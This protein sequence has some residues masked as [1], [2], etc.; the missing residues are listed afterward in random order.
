MVVVEEVRD[1]DGE[2]MLAMG[3]DLKKRQSFDD[4][5]LRVKYVI[6]RYILPRFN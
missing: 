2:R 6:G 5:V 4:I 3:L 1:E